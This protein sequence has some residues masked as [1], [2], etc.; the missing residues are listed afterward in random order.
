M[1]HLLNVN[2]HD[3]LCLSA[4]L[5]QYVKDTLSSQHSTFKLA[6]IASLEKKLIKHFQVKDFLSLEKGT[7]LEF[8]AKHI[9]VKKC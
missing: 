3:L 1:T 9:Q 5:K 2:A 6:H 4:K 7:F 8:L